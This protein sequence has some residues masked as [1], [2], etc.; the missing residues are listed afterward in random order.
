MTYQKGDHVRVKGRH[1]Q[2]TIRAAFAGGKY[3][4]QGF[5]VWSTKLGRVV[6]ALTDD[7][8]RAT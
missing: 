1:G 3:Q 5:W 6:P 4:G 8:R 7:I 2:L